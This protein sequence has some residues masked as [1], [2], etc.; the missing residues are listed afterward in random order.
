[1]G[2]NDENRGTL[3]EMYIAKAYQNFMEMEVAVTAE[4]WGMAANRLYYALY[5][6]TSALFVKDGIPVGSHRGTKAT[7]G[8][9]YII[10]GKFP[11]DFAKLLSQM[12]TLRDKADYNIMFVATRDQIVTKIE[13]A[14]AFIKTI[15]EYVRS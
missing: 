7:F 5:H 2:L 3:V 10:T 14:K 6:A 11:A 15:E 4:M 12:E 1:M 8:Q 9:Y 13:P